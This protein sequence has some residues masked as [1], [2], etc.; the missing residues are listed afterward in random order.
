MEDII[1]V[2]FGGHAKSIADSIERAREY[3]IVGYTDLEEHQT[4]YNY[5]GTDDNLQ[6][7]FDTGV[8]KA[9][10]G[11]GYLGKGDIRNKLYQ[12]LKDIGF[13]LPV[14]VDPSAIVS[15]TVTM[16]EGTFIGKNAIVNADAVVGK[17]AIINTRALVEHECVIEDFVHVAVAAVLCGQVKVGEATFIGANATVIQCMNISAHKTVPAGVTIR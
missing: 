5:L 3:R 14:I 10:I 4:E 1:I 6:V 17:M 16:G 9:V 8:K 11:V 13:E 7:I 2:G 15:K 12:K